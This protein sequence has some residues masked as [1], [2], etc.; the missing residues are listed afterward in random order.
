M[1]AHHATEKMMS[2]RL[3]LLILAAPALLLSGCG[4]TVNRGLEPVHQPV[5]SRSDY[6]FDVKLNDKGGLASGEAERLNGWLHSLRAG[7]GDSIAI[8]DPSAIADTARAQIA[9]LISRDGMF[10]SDQ[11]P[12]TG[13]PTVPGTIRV[14][15]TRSKAS[16]P[17]CPDFS[18]DNKPN[19][20]GH[21][22]SNFGCAVNS[23]LASMVARPEDLVRGQPGATT[24]DQAVAG[25]AIQVL[26]RAAPTGA[27]GIKSEGASK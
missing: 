10:L 20:E 4:G 9:Q 24:S 14:V 15:V 6:S 13:A 12:V 17:G 3:P 26:R 22:S 11:A 23:N 19:F 8:D 25:K 1:T 21:T 16:V 2:K 7:Y 18:R 5:V 27:G